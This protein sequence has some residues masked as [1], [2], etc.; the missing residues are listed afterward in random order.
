MA[1]AFQT[2]G[3]PLTNGL[4]PGLNAYGQIEN[5]AFTPK[6]VSKG[7][8]YTVKASE[9]GTIFL[10]TAALTFTLPAITD[11]PFE[12]RFIVLVDEDVVIAAATADTL[13]TFNDVAA[14]SITFG[15]T[16]EQIGGNAWVICD[17]TTLVCVPCLSGE[18]QTVTVTT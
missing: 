5:I 4:A 12:F 14:D 8:S 16:G 9:S 1:K 13:L 2:N 18:A 15:T 3:M 7:A 17:G 10:A 6:I 11:G